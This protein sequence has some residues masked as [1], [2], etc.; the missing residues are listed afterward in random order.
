MSTPITKTISRRSPRL[1]EKE[2]TEKITEVLDAANIPGFWVF[3]D[4]LF[5]KRW[6][7]EQ[8]LK[9][10]EQSRYGCHCH[11][12]SHEEVENLK[13][14]E[15]YL[16]FNH[17]TKDEVLSVVKA[18]LDL[19]TEASNSRRTAMAIIYTTAMM[20]FVHGPGRLLLKY[21]NFRAMAKTKCSSFPKEVM[22]CGLADS[23]FGERL[24]DACWAVA[25]IID[26]HED[27]DGYSIFHGF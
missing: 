23:E 4:G 27:E 15:D 21:D 1:M 22:N 19:A 25:E 18:F 11:D 3:D 16:P 13:K 10:N 20:R 9:A 6:E 24:L 5:Q 7:Y 12:C 8:L 17:F 2:A 26:Q 14:Y